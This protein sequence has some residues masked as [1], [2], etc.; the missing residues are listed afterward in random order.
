M[1]KFIPLTNYNMVTDG[2]TINIRY[3][4]SLGVTFLHGCTSEI[5]T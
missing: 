2:G 1:L 3:V 5:E 4:A